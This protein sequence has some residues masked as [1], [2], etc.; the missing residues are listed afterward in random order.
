MWFALIC[1]GVF[2]TPDWSPYTM[3]GLALALIVLFELSMLVARVV[4]QQ[5]HQ[6][7]AGGRGRRGLDVVPAEA[8]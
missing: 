6:G 2:V 1:V 8:E 3:G 7:L 4:L 5:A